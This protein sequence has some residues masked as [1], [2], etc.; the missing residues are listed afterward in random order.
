MQLRATL[1]VPQPTSSTAA[2]TQRNE[3]VD[4]RGAG[5]GR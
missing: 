3:L 1:P 5:D 2:R 4:E